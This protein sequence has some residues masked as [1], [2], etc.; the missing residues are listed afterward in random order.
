MSFDFLWETSFGAA[1]TQ[2]SVFSQ[3]S[4]KA[5]VCRQW[6]RR[7]QS[8]SLGKT[9]YER[10]SIS[11]FAWMEE[12]STHFLYNSQLNASRIA[13]SVKISLEGP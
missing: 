9:D 7:A 11:N 12:I 6:A 10:P 1:D 2:G 3:S 13:V 4:K 5:L 8:E